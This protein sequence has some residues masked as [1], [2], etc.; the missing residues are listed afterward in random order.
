M[1]VLDAIGQFGQGFTG[2]SQQ[3]L[4]LYSQVQQ[5]QEQ[6]QLRQRR[7]RAEQEIAQLVESGQF[8]T[9]PIAA[10]K[11]G[12]QI[13]LKNSDFDNYDKWNSNA[14]QL[15]KFEGDRTLMNAFAVAKTDPMAA[16]PLINKYHALVGTGT[17]YDIQR[18]PQGVRL[19]TNVGGKPSAKDYTDMDEL[20]YDILSGVEAYALGPEA[21]GKMEIARS[22]L[23]I[24]EATGMAQARRY[25]AQTESEQAL[26][27]FKQQ[28]L[29]AQAQAS[30][31]SAG[32]SGATAAAASAL[33]AERRALLPGQVA[34]QGLTAAETAKR[35]A[36]IGVAPRKPEP[37]MEELAMGLTGDAPT[38]EFGTPLPSNPF[39]T[40]EATRAG[41]ST[42][43]QQAV[44]GLGK[45]AFYLADRIARTKP[46]ELA[47]ATTNEDGTLIQL[48]DGTQLPLTD[49]IANYLQM[50]KPP[51]LEEE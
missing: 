43:L 15:T 25:Q 46:E 50:L 26:R 7:Q 28:Q 27:P 42:A 38:D 51:T 41:F 17:K 23:G 9:D 6:G 24:K 48:P 32:A 11:A 10:T 39:I 47:Q 13:F 37:T 18:T 1:G 40:D 45:N 49:E 31:A 14:Q 21:T 2:G 44:P 4:D 30:Q 3:G 35:T 22:E 8:K 34:Q 29:T 16:V 5:V 20:G 33:A 36:N 12:A 19:L